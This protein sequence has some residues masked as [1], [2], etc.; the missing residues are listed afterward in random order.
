[1]SYHYKETNDKKMLHS[2]KFNC[3]FDKNDGTCITWGETIDNDVDFCPFGPLIADFEISTVCHGVDGKLC[4]M[5]Y[6]SNSSK[7]DNMSFETF[8]KIADM[9]PKFIQ[10]IA[11]GVSSCATTNPDI[12]KIFSYCR[13]IEIVPNLT[14]ADISND[15]ADKISQYAGACA[16]SVYD[17]KDIAYN[18]IKKLTDRGMTQVNIHRCVFDDTFESTMEILDDIKTDPRLDK[19]NAIVMLQLKQKG[20]GKNLKTLSQEQFNSLA[21]KCLKLKLKF[22]FDSCGGKKFSDFCVKNDRTELLQ[23]VTNCESTLQSIYADVNGNFYPC[24]FCEGTGD[25]KKGI[26]YTEIN[27]FSEL[28]YHE[29][30]VKF[31]DTITKTCGDCFMFKV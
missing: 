4:S 22:G 6:K 25:W 30:I 18:T 21:E 27:S 2:E 23:M 14:V 12:W 28:W 17:N 24:S 26:H 15:T 11:F 19:L 10:Q 31:R 29:K 13:Q 7:G 8:K 9:L 16:V 20:R 5:C 3:V 1:M